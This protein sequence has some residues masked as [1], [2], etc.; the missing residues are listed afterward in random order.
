MRNEILTKFRTCPSAL[1]ALVV[2]LAFSGHIALAQTTGFSYQ[3]S[4][5][6][7]GA[8]AN[9]N[10]DF[11]FRLWN[12]ASGGA[13]IGTTVTL[14][15]VESFSHVFDSQHSVNFRMLPGRYGERY[16]NSAGDVLAGIKSFDL[17]GDSEITWTWNLARSTP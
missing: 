7:A 1:F 14:N 2:A 6:N 17:P 10:H 3:G 15:G 4:L 11:E 12:S 9:G 8:P 5:K 16:A 13:Q